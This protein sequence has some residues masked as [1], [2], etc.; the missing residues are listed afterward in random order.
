MFETSA[1]QAAG[2]AVLPVLVWALCALGLAR[3]TR[4]VQHHASSPEPA[5]GCG[6]GA[7][8]NMQGEVVLSVLHHVLTVVLFWQFWLKKKKKHT[9]PIVW[10][11][12]GVGLS[13]GGGQ[14]EAL[15]GD[16]SLCMPQGSCSPAA[17]LTGQPVPVP[18]PVPVW[19]ALWPQPIACCPVMLRLLPCSMPAAESR[20]GEITPS[21]LPASATRCLSPGW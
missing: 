3:C 9:P 2:A 4:R 6:A 18:V 7:A 15:L 11:H 1:R 21:V 10:E 19:G 14:V 16:S 20:F 13:P 5:A 12:R 17:G 8:H